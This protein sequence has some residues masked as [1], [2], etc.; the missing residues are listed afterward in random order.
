MFK[1]CLRFGLVLLLASMTASAEAQVVQGGIRGIVSDE[2]A[3][4][5]IG[6]TVETESPARIGAPAVTVTNNMGLYRFEGIPVG[7]YTVTFTLPGFTTIRRENVDVPMGR[8]VQL[9]MTLPVAGA[10]ETVTVTAA[11]PVID[12][13]HADYSTNF[14]QELVKNIPTTR[15]AYFDVVT[16][17]PGVKHQASA[18][19]TNFSIYGSNTD[20]NSY[21]YDGV[22]V[23]SVGSGG[24]WDYPNYD[25]IQEIEVLSVG[26]SAEFTGFQGGV[27]NIVT[28]SGSNRFSGGVGYYF[29]DDWM[30]GNNTPEEE[31]PPQTD[32]RRDLSYEIGGPIIKDRLWFFHSFEY[33][34][35]RGVP[36]G[37]ELIPEVPHDWQAIPQ[38]KITAQLTENDTLEG[39]YQNNI[40]DWANAPSRSQ[41]H[42]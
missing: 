29:V 24:P 22:D 8:T 1:N 42:S 33:I 27:I 10:Q 36:I 14:A 18:N 3:G 2:T 39:M 5:L 32:Y 7:I 35:A 17:I 41:A 19:I 31:F 11:S 20:Q 13:V 15:D 25:M 4:V 12:T 37:V 6:V 28:K 23:S 16:S 38:F 34:G 40:F 21:Q 30:V 26:A 9:N